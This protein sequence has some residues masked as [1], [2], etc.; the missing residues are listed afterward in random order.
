MRQLIDLT[1]AKIGRLLVLRRA[2]DYISPSGKRI[3]QFLCRCEC[4]SEVVVDSY[5]LRNGRKTSCGCARLSR[6]PK[7]KVAEN[8]PPIPGTCFYHPFG[9]DCSDNHK[10]SK[11][12]WNPTNTSLRKAR[13]DKLLGKD[14]KDE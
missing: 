13:I 1:G 5:R 9:V 2:T 14:G 8:L 10:C 6:K 4:G 7:G 3:P 11:C 12:G